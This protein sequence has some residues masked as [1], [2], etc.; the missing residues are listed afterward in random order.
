TTKSN[1]TLAMISSTALDLPLHRERVKSACMQTG[2]RPTMQE[3]MTAGGGTPLQ[4]SLAMVDRAGVYIGILGYRY[5]YVPPGQSV[6]ITEMEYERAFRRGI[7]R[8][9]FLMNDKHMV[10][11]SDVETGAGSVKLQAF[12]ARVARENVV[13]EFSSPEDLSARVREALRRQR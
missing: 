9:M 6:S 3:K 12:R 1:K 8:L 11:P 2:F 10:R 7:P 13:K 4:E 5:G